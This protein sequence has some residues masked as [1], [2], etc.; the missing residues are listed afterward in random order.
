LRPRYQPL[1]Q[2]T[3]PEV[4]EA[5]EP[6]RLCEYNQREKE[7]ADQTVGLCGRLPNLDNFRCGC[8]GPHLPVED[9]DLVELLE[10]KKALRP[11][12]NS[13]SRISDISRQLEASTPTIEV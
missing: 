6:C 1:Q 12:D 4:D 9:A 7:A 5:S 11:S 3:A 2:Q 10:P 8:H 13:D